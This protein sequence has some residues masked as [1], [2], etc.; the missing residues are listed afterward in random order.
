MF[1]T[2]IRNGTKKL[3]L[4]QKVAKTGRVNANVT[5]LFVGS[6]A[7]DSEI[8]YFLGFSITSGSIGASRDGIS[9]LKLFVRVVDEILFVRHVVD[10]EV[11]DP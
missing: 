1:E 8:A 7:S 5:P 2:A 4:Q 10:C 9:S 3:G 6:S 11:W